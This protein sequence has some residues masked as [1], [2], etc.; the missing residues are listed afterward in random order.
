M[1]DSEVTQLLQDWHGGDK[2]ALDKLMP[3]VLDELRRIAIG[4]F[5]REAP[6]HTL[7]PTAVVN[8]VYLRLV[9]ADRVDWQCRAQFFG[10]TAR[11]MRQVLVDHARGRNAE[12]RWGGVRRTTIEVDRIASDGREVDLIALDDALNEMARINPE[13]SRIVEMRYFT[14]L[15]LEEVAE[16]LGVGRSTVKRRWRAAK[17]WLHHELSREEGPASTGGES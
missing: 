5:A 7:Q 14:G 8:E 16:V 15:T 9:D 6:G 1:L 3:M 10:I 12:K 2:E 4:H 11:L 13:G 17:L